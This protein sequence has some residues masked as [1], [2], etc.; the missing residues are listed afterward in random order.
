MKTLLKS[1]L[2]LFLL[3]LHSNASAEK[4]NADLIQL[5]T[6]PITFNRASIQAFLTDV[7]NH[8]LY[9]VYGL[10]ASFGHITDLL[11]YNK[12]AP[13]PY[14]Y[15]ISIIDLFHDRLKEALWVNPYALSQLLNAVQEHC[16]SLCEAPQNQQ[17]A[18]KKILYQAL[19]SQFTD[20]KRN[21]EQF[22]DNVSAQIAHAV[23]GDHITLRLE[24]QYALTRFIES[25]LDKL[26]AEQLHTLYR[27]GMMPHETALNHC[28]WSLIYRFC[29]FIDTVGEHLSIPTYEAIKHDMATKNSPLFCLEES[30]ACITTKAQKLQLSVFDNEVKVRAAQS[31]LW[32]Q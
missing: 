20:L 13:Q 9:G 27:L 5:F 12:S 14:V 2:F 15:T 4:L 24:L 25:A 21:P 26:V 7:F 19:L 23:S 31:G 6:R 1:L 3:S 8:R 28:Y 18:I 10:P 11:S 22:M 32:V 29:Y 30:E 16:Q 17:D